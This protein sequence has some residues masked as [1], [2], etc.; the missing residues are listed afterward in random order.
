MGMAM[1][2]HVLHRV[3]D[4]AEPSALCTWDSPSLQAPACRSHRALSTTFLMLN[5]GLGEGGK[6][7]PVP[8]HS[9]H[10]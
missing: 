9:D 8:L 6:L 10:T 1:G 7:V 4:A 2:Q 3:S 5:S